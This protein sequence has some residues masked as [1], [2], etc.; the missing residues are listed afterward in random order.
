MPA[1][2]QNGV[3]KTQKERRRT[4][5][6][7]DPEE[8][9]E[10]DFCARKGVRI[11]RRHQRAA[12]TGFVRWLREN[13]DIGLVLPPRRGS[14]ALKKRRE[15][16]RG[17]MLALLEEGTHAEN[18]AERWRIGALRYFHDVSLKT[19]QQVRD[20]DVEEDLD[21]LRVHIKDASYWIPATPPTGSTS[22]GCTPATRR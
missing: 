7:S 21:G 3:A 19:A 6:V 2:T 22:S 14:R 4:I 11:K 9:A 10:C 8:W 15:R 12:L 1:L 18:F 17:E 5:K 16:A 20:S 13:H